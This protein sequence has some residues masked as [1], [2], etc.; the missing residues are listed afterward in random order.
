MIHRTQEDKYNIKRSI[1]HK[2]MLYIILLILIALGINT[3]IAV[4]TESNVLRGS[5]I[6]L[7]NHTARGIVSSVK[8]AFWSLNWIFVEKQLQESVQCFKGELIY[9]KIVKSNGEVYLAS[10]RA[11]YG[12]IID[13]SLLFDQETLLD[14]YSFP[15]KEEN[16]MIVVQPIDIGEER[17]YVLLGLS[18]QTVREA[19]RS[20]ILR[21]VLWGILIL[22][23]AIIGSFFLSKS[24]TNPIISLANAANII[25]GGNWDHSVSIKSNDEVGLLSHSFNRMIGSLKRS[26][27]A[28]RRAND[29]LERRV[30][31]RT[32]ELSK[33]NK[34]LRA[35]IS[36][37]KQV[38]ESLRKAHA[39][40]EIRVKERTAEL[41]KANK[42]LEEAKIAADDA[43]QAKSEFL[44]CMSHELRTPLNSVIGFSEILRD[45]YFGNLNEKQA[46]YVNDILES[47]KHLL[48]LINDILDISKIEAGKVEL[49]LSRS[50]SDNSHLQ[51]IRELKI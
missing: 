43:N 8:S 29:E 26:D 30:E 21:N 19:S 50:L 34:E 35:E 18:L 2:L 1:L 23:V 6:H 10:D 36:K 27:E 39:E 11:Y 14:N 47:G 51:K 15:E 7:G 22:L 25:S 40:L 42:E 49:E 33:A 9:S 5:L 20:L 46:D 17:W 45:K 38:E 28:L 16:G 32:S 44:A 37:R 12:D 3:Y 41:V 48:S 4:R 13:S 31:E 24:I